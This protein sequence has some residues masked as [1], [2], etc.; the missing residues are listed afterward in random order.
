MTPKIVDFWGFY[1]FKFKS[2]FFIKLCLALVD[3]FNAAV[4]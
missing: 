3:S 1:E 4:F 2:I